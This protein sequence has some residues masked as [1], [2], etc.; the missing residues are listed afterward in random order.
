MQ[1]R[2]TSHLCP[3]L[4][5]ILNADLMKIVES[6][7]FTSDFIYDEI[8]SLS[9]NLNDTI[10]FCW[11]PPAFTPVPSSCED[12]L[13]PGITHDG[14]CFTFNGLNSNEMYTDA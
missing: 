11:P 6:E 4:L 3:T 9:P 13:T 8:N 5:E 14:L 7:N 2:V 10:M 12:F 1:I